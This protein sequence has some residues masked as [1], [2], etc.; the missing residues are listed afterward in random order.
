MVNIRKIDRVGSRY[1]QKTLPVS[2]T[3]F[4]DSS[5]NFRDKT[6]SRK[7]KCILEQW[8][9]LKLENES[10]GLLKGFI[11]E[12]PWKKHESVS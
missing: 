1:H 12:V 5:P 3:V 2:F 7:L 9:F 11:L 8:Y 4:S 10:M 6:F